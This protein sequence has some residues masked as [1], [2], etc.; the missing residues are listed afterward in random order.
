[1]IITYAIWF[2]ELNSIVSRLMYWNSKPQYDCIW[3]ESSK[4]VINV[5]WGSKCKTLF[6]QDGVLIKRAPDTKNMHREKAMW[7][8]REKVGTLMR[9]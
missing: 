6:Q 4:V 5:E 3:R 9:N 1:M 8:H 7:E 2:L